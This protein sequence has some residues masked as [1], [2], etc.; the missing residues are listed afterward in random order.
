HKCVWRVRST[1]AKRVALQYIVVGDATEEY[2]AVGDAA[3]RYTVVGDAAARFTVGGNKG[4]CRS[5]G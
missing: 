3:A 4:N 5:L 1:A 2:A